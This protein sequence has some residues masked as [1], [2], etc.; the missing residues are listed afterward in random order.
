MIHLIKRVGQRV[1][2]TRYLAYKMRPKII[3]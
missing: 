3:H 1:Q 2:N